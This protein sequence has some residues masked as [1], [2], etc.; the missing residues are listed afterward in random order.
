MSEAFLSRR[1]VFKGVMGAA[2][3]G[4]SARVLPMFSTPSKKQTPESCPSL[5]LS[6]SEKTVLVSSWP[7]Y[8]DPISEDGST[9]A[10]FRQATGITVTYTEDV[11]DNQAFF[12]KV[13]N[14]LGTC[15]PVERDL[16]V[17][18]DWTVSRM[19]QL[20]WL[21][22][23]DHAHLA[24]VDAQLLPE[25]QR[26]AFDS[27]RR[28]SVPWQG[29]FTGLAYNAKLVPEVRSVKDLLTRD[30]L[31]GR[32]TLLSEMRDTMGL[33]LKSID[34]NPGGFSDAEWHVALESLRAAR[35]RGQIRAFTGNEYVRGLAAGNIAACLAWSSD[36]QQLSDNPDL[37]FV[38]PEEGLEFWSDNMV[39]PNL[40]AHK[41]NA[42]AWMNY[43]YDPVVAA[44][45]ASRI[46]CICPVAGARAAMEKIDPSLV[47]NPLIFPSSEYLSRTWEF[48]PLGETQSRLYERDFRDAIGG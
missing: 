21:Q 22:P 42:E 44:T 26:V 17:V 34:A 15:Q 38:V 14:Q 30:D 45:L 40:A 8:I 25:L 27:G 20:G 39:V 1:A 6:A 36:I 11:N 28:Y 31:R 7:S 33:L 19:M 5:D 37:K 43:F 2:A 29:G 4:I 10:G 24:N 35:R 41:T 47:D 16:F 3:L 32:V 23:L 46:R 12:A 18:T 9:V 13:S 48:M